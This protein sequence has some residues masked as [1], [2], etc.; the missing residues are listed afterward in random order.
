MQLDNILVC[1]IRPSTHDMLHKFFLTRERPDM[2]Q[3]LEY[4][5]KFTDSEL[6][7]MLAGQWYKS[8]HSH[9]GPK[10]TWKQR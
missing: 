6:D 1:A 9:T 3:K 2:Y 10:L 8:M 4:T 5:S 7:P